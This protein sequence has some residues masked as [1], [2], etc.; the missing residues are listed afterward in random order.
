MS[1]VHVVIVKTD[2]NIPES[3][4]KD[5]SDLFS[6]SL[7]DVEITKEQNE[8]KILSKYNPSN[9]T[10]Y[11]L[12][13]K[14]TAVT[15]LNSNQMNIAISEMIENTFYDLYFLSSWND[16]C[17]KYQDVDSKENLK[18]TNNGNVNLANMYSPNARTIILNGKRM[19]NGKYFSK[20]DSE[21]SKNLANA[22]RDGNLTA[23][24]SVP[25]I[26]T[27]NINFSTS[28]LD[29]NKLNK[30]VPVIEQAPPG[31]TTASYLWFF[32][33]LVLIVLLAWALIKLGPK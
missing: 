8:R 2:E 33:F 5:L 28:S 25:N 21:F 31:N 26:F 6:S 15:Y 1:K 11:V 7:F 18:V 13:L 24:T 12:I 23:V 20:G 17:T 30:C 32:I 10:D 14:D 16:S 27:F 3:H 4:I 19:K 9:N 29:V 22:V